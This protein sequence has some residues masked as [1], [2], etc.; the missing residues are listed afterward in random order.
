MWGMG[1]FQAVMI[2]VLSLRLRQVDDLQSSEG[3]PSQE[4]E[5]KVYKT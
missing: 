4:L 5:T 1:I 2:I 3:R